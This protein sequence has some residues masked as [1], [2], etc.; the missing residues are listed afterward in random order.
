M[1]LFDV[2][3]N[4]EF[5]LSQV[6]Q[7]EIFERYLVAVTYEGRICSPLRTDKTATCGFK[8]LRNGV[9]MFRDFSGHFSGDCFNV[10]QHIYGC[11][12]YEALSIISVD[13]GLTAGES[14]EPSGIVEWNSEKEYT[15]IDVKW[16]AFTK[17]DMR[18]WELFGIE[19]ATLVKYMVGAVMYAWVNGNVIYH[20]KDNDPCYGYWFDGQYKLY[21]PKRKEYRF[22]NNYLGL[23]G[24]AQLPLKG[25]L[26]V[27]TKSMKDVMYL[28]QL[29]IAAIA[30]SSESVI[31][32]HDKML[33][34]KGR[35]DNIII[36][37]DF[38]L[39]GV[40]S[41]NAMRKLYDLPYVFI[42]NGRFG[43]V[44]YGAKDITDVHK[45]K[46]ENVVK[47][48]DL[49]WDSVLNKK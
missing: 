40:R 24:E 7:E 37:F 25:P 26:L 45:I 5:V 34:L 47:I 16:R 12:F 38:D 14:R 11:S 41:T 43:T 9:I 20:N 31:L 32:S 35:F 23:Q 21:M 49:I 22:I 30:T 8:R 44:D 39:T 27:I 33:E 19:R 36:M 4:K 15:H 13:F 18:Y 6:S 48:K 2:E 46:R 3:I 28:F 17:A 10:V 42:T 1:N 29:G